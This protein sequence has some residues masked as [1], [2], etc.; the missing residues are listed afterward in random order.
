MTC[1]VTVTIQQYVILAQLCIAAISQFLFTLET[2]CKNSNVQ[3]HVFSI[4]SKNY[5][6]IL[7]NERV[8]ES[9]FLE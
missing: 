2:F 7:K 9:S 8:M 4:S 1:D 5:I 3:K 6:R